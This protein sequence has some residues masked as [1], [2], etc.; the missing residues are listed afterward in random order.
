[1]KSNRRWI[2]ALTA[3][4]GA[5][6]NGAVNSVAATTGE[7]AEAAATMSSYEAQQKAAAEAREKDPAW[8]PACAEVGSIQVGDAKNPGALR[9]F[10]LNTDGN[11]LACFAAR[12]TA[13]STDAKSVSGIR[14]YSPAGALLKTLPLDI[15]PCAVCVAKDGTIFVAGD[16]RLLKLDQEG[17]VLASADSPVAKVPVVIGKEI[18]EM[19]KQSGRTAKDELPKMKASLEMRRADVTGLAVTDEDVFLACPSP[20]DFSYQVYRLDHSLANPKLVVEKLRGCCGQMDIQ[21]H[22]GKLWIPHNARHQVECCDRDGKQLAK[23][24]KSGKVKPDDFGGCCEPKNV[25]ILPNGDILAA[26]SGPPTCIKRFTAD[27]KF[28]GVVAVVKGKGDCVRVT[29]EISAD[30]SRYYMLDTARDA[31]RIFGAKS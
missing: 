2:V 24:G 18:E 28:L 3:M 19:L 17:K 8:K 16:G 14:V 12:E 11:I 22:D 20:G 1:M 6:L 30:G 26:E 9:N 21:A 25:R 10:C 7:V 31:I 29:V 27:G 15:K 13:K 5:Y 23:F 4:T